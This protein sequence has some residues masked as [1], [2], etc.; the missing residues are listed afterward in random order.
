MGGR[1][2]LAFVLFA[3]WF[4]LL[5]AGLF[6]P[7]AGKLSLPFW[8]EKLFIVLCVLT[9][10]C[11]WL[12]AHFA[13]ALHYAYLYYRQDRG[14]LDFP[15]NEPLDLMDFAYFA[16]TVGTTAASSDVNITSREVRRVVM[17]HTLFSFVFNTAIL[18]LTLQFAVS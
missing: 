13:Y 6:L 9:V 1:T 12:M 17:G 16:F 14:G 15:G 3:S 7:L 2:G 11:A 10:A 4:G 18:A 5:V 8:Q